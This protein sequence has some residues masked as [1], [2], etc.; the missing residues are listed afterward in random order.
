MWNTPVYNICLLRVPGPCIPAIYLDVLT[1]FIN[2]IY[3][4]V[5]NDGFEPG[6]RLYSIWHADQGAGQKLWASKPLR[7]INV[8]MF[9]CYFNFSIDA[10][11]FIW[12]SINLAIYV[13]PQK[14]SFAYWLTKRE[15]K[16]DV[17]GS[18]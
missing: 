15:A 4:V 12:I 1:V 8:I 6:H 11:A 14:H 17:Y 10:F 3:I 2:R 5:R 7:D 13:L 9:S 18:I 16:I